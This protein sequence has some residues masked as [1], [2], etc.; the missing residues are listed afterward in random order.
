M[1]RKTFSGS[2]FLYTPKVL[3]I[4]MLEVLFNS[5]LCSLLAY[6][7]FS[8]LI[9]DFLNPIPSQLHT[10]LSGTGLALENV[11]QGA[12]QGASIGCFFLTKGNQQAKI[13]SARMILDANR[14]RCVQEEKRESKLIN[15]SYR[16]FFTT[17][18]KMFSATMKRKMREN[19]K[20]G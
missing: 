3:T 17:N 10:I 11:C 1:P 4:I 13:R 6:F 15:N 5:P 8:K 7:Q 2:L 14:I 18:E 16:V 12:E 20:G 19:K 9:L